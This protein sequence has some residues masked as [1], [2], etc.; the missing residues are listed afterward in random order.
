[1]FYHMRTVSDDGGTDTVVV[2]PVPS[3]KANPTSSLSR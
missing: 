1:M 3:K 2:A